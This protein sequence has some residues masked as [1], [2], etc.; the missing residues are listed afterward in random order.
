MAHVRKFLDLSTNHLMED[1]REFLRV[2][3]L[4]AD[5]PGLVCVQTASGG[6]FM[7]ADEASE[8]DLAQVPHRICIIMIR[9]RQYGC[10]YVLFDEN[11]PEDPD[12]PVFEPPG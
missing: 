2:A 5:N 7:H 4:T 3:S 6:W 11:G 10:D 8:I 12:L 9:A 1:D